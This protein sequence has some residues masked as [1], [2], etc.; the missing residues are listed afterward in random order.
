[1]KRGAT[2]AR[3]SPSE[4]ARAFALR[5]AAAEHQADQLSERVA[6]LERFLRHD[7]RTPITILLGHAQMLAEGLVAPSRVADSYEAM[8]RQSARLT[9][10]VE[11]L[12]DPQP[13]DRVPIWVITADVIR[14][15]EAVRG[16]GVV[17]V[18]PETAALLCR[19][20]DRLLTLI[21]DEDARAQV[22]RAAFPH[23]GDTT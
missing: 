12:G 7:L 6:R 4:L 19:P 16:L 8:T 21:P 23:N 15:T 5:A 2:D 22:L 10:A 1:M 14:T 17:V 9:A 3:V 20:S 11:A 18:A 13:P